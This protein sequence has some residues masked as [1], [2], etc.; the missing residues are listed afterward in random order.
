MPKNTIEKT[1]PY[2]VFRRDGG[3]FVRIN[4]KRVYIAHKHPNRK[5]PLGDTQVVSRRQ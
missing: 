2:R 3:Y 5:R 4:N 1:R